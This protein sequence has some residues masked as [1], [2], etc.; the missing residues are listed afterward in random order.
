M[1][2]AEISSQS[3]SVIIRLEAVTKTYGSGDTIVHALD[4]VNLIVHQ[5]EYCYGDRHQSNWCCQWRS[6][7]SL[8]VSISVSDRSGYLSHEGEFI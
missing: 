2:S 3:N 1:D 8:A 5:G 7:Q 6:T 4:R